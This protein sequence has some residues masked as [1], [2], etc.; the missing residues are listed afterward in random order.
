M[1]EVYIKDHGQSPNNGQG[2]FDNEQCWE[3]SPSCIRTYCTKI[4]KLTEQYRVPTNK[5]EHGMVYDTWSRL[6]VGV[7]GGNVNI[8]R[9]VMRQL[10]ICTGKS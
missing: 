2:N 8:Q 5:S 1:S 3:M 10:F 4:D 7:W 6:T 9:V